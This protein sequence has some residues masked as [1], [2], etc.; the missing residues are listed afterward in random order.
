LGGTF[1]NGNRVIKSAL[2]FGDVIT[3]GAT[4][5]LFEGALTG[6]VG[7]STDHPQTIN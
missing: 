7:T 6:I 5:I 4:D 2:R 3:V 1:V